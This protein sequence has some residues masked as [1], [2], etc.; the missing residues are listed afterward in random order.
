MYMCMSACTYV[1][2]YT[3]IDMHMHM[4]MCMYIYTD[5]LRDVRLGMESE[6][7]KSL[8][9]PHTT[10]WPHPPNKGGDVNSTLYSIRKQYFIQYMQTVLYTVYVYSTLSSICI[11]YSIKYM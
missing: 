8:A 5:T 7:S 11:Q 1:Y 6:Q 2:V 4:Y 3:Y 10:R 9:S